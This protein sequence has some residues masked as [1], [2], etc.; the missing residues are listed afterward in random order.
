[1]ERT[2]HD[3]RASLTIRFGPPFTKTLVSM[4]KRT[5]LHPL[6]I[7]SAP[8]DDALFKLLSAELDSRL[9][10]VSGDMEALHRELLRLPR[11]LRAMGATH[12]LDVSMALDDLG[13]HFGNWPS[14][15][16][17]KETLEG[18]KELGA[19]EAAEI[20]ESALSHALANWSFVCSGDFS[21]KYHGSTLEQTLEPLN[22]RLWKLLGYDGGP[23]KNLLAY[24]APYARA[25]PDRVWQ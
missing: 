6:R 24:W 16:L 21:D 13:W 14:Q 10:P 22:W 20:F 18:L 2:A 9:G 23:G 12:P 7:T 15:P 4:K 1:V 3:R 5:G 17:A 19:A 8:D 25:H 11:G